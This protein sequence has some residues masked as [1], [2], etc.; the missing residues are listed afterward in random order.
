MRVKTQLEVRE[1]RRKER[2]RRGETRQQFSGDFY[3][4]AFVIDRRIAVF[5]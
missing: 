5:A 3:N 2:E 1:E 4:I